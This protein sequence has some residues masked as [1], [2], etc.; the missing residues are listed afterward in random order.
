MPCASARDLVSADAKPFLLPFAV[1]NTSTW[2]YMKEASFYCGPRQG[3]AIPV[4]NVVI[5]GIRFQSNVPKATIVAGSTA[6][7]RCPVTNASGNMVKGTVHPIID[8]KTSDPP[9]LTKVRI[10]PVSEMPTR[11]GG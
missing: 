11:H 3:Q 6:N 5:C 1:T 10:R 8:Y 7:F 9:A 4:G 2:F